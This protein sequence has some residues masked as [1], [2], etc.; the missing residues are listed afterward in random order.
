M[1]LADPSAARPVLPGESA[2]DNPAWSSLT[3]F[4]APLAI[5]GD[6]VRRYP[7]DVS[8]FMGVRD[9]ADPDVWEAIIELMGHDA[10][11]GISHAEP[12]LPAGWTEVYRVPGVQLVQTEQLSPRPDAEAVELGAQD[13]AE[14]MDLVERT[15][16][17]P[18]RPRTHEM[19]RYVGVRRGGRLVA[20]AG[21][22]LHPAGWTE[23]SAVCVDDRFRR[24][25]L[26]SRMVLDI[27]FHIQQRGDRALLHASAENTGAIRAYEKLGFRLRRRLS[28]WGARTPR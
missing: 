19:G 14:M 16:P 6:L 13:A 9:F 18:F 24:Q 20:M 28:F 4:H 12:V 10:E 15:R 17:G 25:G 2:L 8:P 22:R 26:A 3:G 7:E 27:A 11:V 1:V 23:I 5:G 21:E